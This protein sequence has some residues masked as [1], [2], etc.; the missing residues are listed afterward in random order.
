MNTLNEMGLDM[1]EED[2]C[3]MSQK[4]Q[5]LILFKNVVYIRRR[6]TEYNLTKKLQYWW[7]SILTLV[8]LSWLG[9]KYKLGV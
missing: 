8:L 7:L 5:N 1:S 9:I 6:F 4:D 2:F 3:K